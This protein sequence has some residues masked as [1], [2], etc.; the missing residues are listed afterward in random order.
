MSS[1]GTV[2]GR[3]FVISYSVQSG[4]SINRWIRGSFKVTIDTVVTED[5]GEILMSGTTNN[6]TKSDSHK[7]FT[8]K[9]GL[10]FGTKSYDGES[11]TGSGNMKYI[12]GS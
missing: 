1:A 3:G 7:F 2:N 5:A 8:T 4:L 12:L 9:I 6:K 11:A 10:E